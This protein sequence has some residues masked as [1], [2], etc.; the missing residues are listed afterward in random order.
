MTFDGPAVW[1]RINYDMAFDVVAACKKIRHEN[2]V[3]TCRNIKQDNV[4]EETNI[5]IRGITGNVATAQ[6]RK[7]CGFWRDLITYIHCW[8]K[9]KEGKKNKRN[10]KVI[11]NIKLSIVDVDSQIPI[12]YYNTIFCNENHQ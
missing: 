11:H 8:T 10:F 1:N 2:K 6:R 9:D 3:F 4:M 5:L 12:P 7:Y